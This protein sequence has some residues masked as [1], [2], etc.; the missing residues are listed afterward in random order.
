[1]T[2]IWLDDM[3]GSSYHDQRCPC[4]GHCGNCWADLAE[5]R[6]VQARLIAEHNPAAP[7]RPLHPLARYCS[8]YCR[9]RAKRERA[10]DRRLAS[11]AT[12]L[13]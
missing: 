11:A 12:A 9:D 2:T 10:L 4:P 5:V 8:P 6:A 3:P 7:D 13:T 1:M